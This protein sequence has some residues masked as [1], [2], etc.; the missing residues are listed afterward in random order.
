MTQIRQRSMITREGWYYLG[1]LGFVVLGSLVRNI[2][3]L[4]G[5]SAILATAMV[6][7][8]RWSRLSMQKLAI[9]RRMPE[10]VW[11]ERLTHFCCDVQN[12]RSRISSFSVVVQQQFGAK[13]LGGLSPPVGRVERLR[14]F[15]F[16]RPPEQFV[17]L[18]AIHAGQT[19]TADQVVLFRRRGEYQVGPLVVSTHFP[20][21]LVQR[22]RSDPQKLPLFVGPAIGSLSQNWVDQM[23]GL[24]WRDSQAGRT[25]RSGEE[26]FSLRPYTRGDSQRL[27]HWRASARHSG[28]L[29][30]QFQQSQ[31][32]SFT[33]IID[34]TDPSTTQVGTDDWEKLLRVAA[35]ISDSVRQGRWTS[36][37]MILV[38]EEEASICFPASDEQ[39]Q[40]WHRALAMARANRDPLRL[41]SKLQQEVGTNRNAAQSRPPAVVLST[42]SIEQYVAFLREQPATAQNGAAPSTD[43]SY[44][45]QFW[46]LQTVVRSWLTPGDPWL[47]GWYC[48]VDGAEQQ[49]EEP[50]SPG[51]VRVPP[52]VSRVN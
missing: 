7:N 41:F 32:K 44:L 17:L 31:A 46:S 43:P 16:G 52:E 8:W 35:T 38:A 24:G 22:F 48:E 39:W 25:S 2:Q 23:L 26:F 15:F 33:L 13:K 19:V 20:L 34:L 42:Y 51:H 1:I 28:L 45:N 10:T 9:R 5:L 6:F 14:N 30:R 27:I 36:V 3:I 29:V 49:I 18:D 47:S 40:T 11:A 21:G 50:D 37:R 12:Q 4:V